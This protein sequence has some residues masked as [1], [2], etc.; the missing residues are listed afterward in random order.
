MK[1]S[2]IG[3]NNIDLLLCLYNCAKSQGPAFIPLYTKQVEHINRLTENLTGNRQ[4]AE[5]LINSGQTSFCYLDLGAGLRLLNISLGNAAREADRYI[6]TDGYDHYNGKNWGRMVVEFMRA[7]IIKNSRMATQL[8]VSGERVSNLLSQYEV[9][10]N[11]APGR[12]Y[13]SQS[14]L[15]SKDSSQSRT[16]RYRIE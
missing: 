7:E 11:S 5:I 10:M 6:E 16:K 2:T 12:G 13:D 3:I 8:Y 1:I 9:L 15:E 4:E 14:Y